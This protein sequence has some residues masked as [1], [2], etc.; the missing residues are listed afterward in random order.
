MAME[1]AAEWTFLLYC[2]TIDNPFSFSTKELEKL[3]ADEL[4]VAGDA[5]LA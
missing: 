1:S 2:G 4:I 3:L 5:T